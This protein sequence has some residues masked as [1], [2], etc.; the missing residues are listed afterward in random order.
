MEARAM[1]DPGATEP[2]MLLALVFMLATRLSPWLRP[3]GR[4]ANVGNKI[5]SRGQGS[6]F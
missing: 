5:Y 4:S 2:T 1:V 3:E 6:G